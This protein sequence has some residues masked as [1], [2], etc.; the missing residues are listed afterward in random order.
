MDV[1]SARPDSAESRS[2]GLPPPSDILA[3]SPSGEIALLLGAQNVGAFEIGGT[4]AE[5]PLAGG[6]PREILKA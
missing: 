1:F 6:A 4:L 3:V 2:L 5:M